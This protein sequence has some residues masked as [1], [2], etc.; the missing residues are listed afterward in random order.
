MKTLVLSISGMTCDH[1]VKSVDAA[2][3]KLP[4]ILAGDVTLGKAVV[5]FDES[6]LT[7]AELFASIR[8]AGVYEITGF[9]ESALA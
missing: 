3:R 4:G 7:K 8:R 5:T 2:V 9:T 6:L 1:C